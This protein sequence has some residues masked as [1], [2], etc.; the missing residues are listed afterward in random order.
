M[1]CHH[2]SAWR[3]LG[4]G[5]G[6][7]RHH[8]LGRQGRARRHGL[9]WRGRARHHGLGR[10]GMAWPGMGCQ[11]GLGRLVTIGAGSSSWLGLAG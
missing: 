1:E 2:G 3:G 9:G 6:K 7:A 5:R 4:R 8:G 11:H 10:A